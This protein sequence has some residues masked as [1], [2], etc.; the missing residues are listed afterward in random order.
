[1]SEIYT[2]PV[3]INGIVPNHFTMSSNNSSFLCIFFYVRM[4]KILIMFM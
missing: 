1:M 4:K 3:I 2:I